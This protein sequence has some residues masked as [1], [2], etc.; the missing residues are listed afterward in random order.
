MEQT[1]MEYLNQAARRQRGRACLAT[2]SGGV[3]V[4]RLV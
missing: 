2:S 3:D 4:R 1:D